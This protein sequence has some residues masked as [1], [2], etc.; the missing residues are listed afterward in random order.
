VCAIIVFHQF[1]L[2]PCIALISRNLNRPLILFVLNNIFNVFI[3][4]KKQ[5]K[6]PS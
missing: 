6:P 2:F 1:I 3:K 4:I 5:K